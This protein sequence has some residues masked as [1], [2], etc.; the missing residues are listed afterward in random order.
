MYRNIV[1]FL[2]VLVLIANTSVSAKEFKDKDILGRWFTQES[3]HKIDQNNHPVD[4][5]LCMS[6]EYF[7]NHMSNGQGE[8]VLNSNFVED[9]D[10]F[11]ITMAWFFRGSVEW[12][13][14]EQS[15]IEKIVD[16]KIG[17]NYVVFEINGNKVEDESILKTF[18]DKFEGIN[19]MFYVGM[20]S[21]SRITSFE[22]DFFITEELQD[23]GSKRIMQ[24]N[25][26]NKMIEG[27]R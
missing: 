12:Q 1:F 24:F 27:C 23:D 21:D 19:E 13:I 7:K 4:I 14:L 17:V 22:K 25:R 9:N 10:S 3:I 2:S 16:I 15:L 8:I 11:Q 18:R 6:S 5:K 20:T 26:T